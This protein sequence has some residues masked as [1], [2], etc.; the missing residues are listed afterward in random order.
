[1]RNLLKIWLPFILVVP[2]VYYY[3]AVLSSIRQTLSTPGSYTLP[4]SQYKV[5]EMNDRVPSFKLA[6]IDGH[7]PY[8]DGDRAQ[9][10]V[11]NSLQLVSKCKQDPSL[12][13]V[14]VG[15]FLGSYIFY[16]KKHEINK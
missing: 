8:A 5:V 12:I 3:S 14:D 7:K 11:I 10:T 9:A 1:M 16:L 13:V 4:P 2:L 6:T 15:G